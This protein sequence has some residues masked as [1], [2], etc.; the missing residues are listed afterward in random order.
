MFLTDIYTDNPQALVGMNPEKPQQGNLLSTMDTW[1]L[2]Y[3]VSLEIFINTAPQEGEFFNIFHFTTGGW[4]CEN[5]QRTPGLY[6]QSG[7]TLVVYNLDLYPQFRTIQN[8]PVQQW[9][10]IKMLQCYEKVN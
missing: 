7:P 5:G 4:C 2:T 1:G 3:I 6:F 10:H 9:I 8:I